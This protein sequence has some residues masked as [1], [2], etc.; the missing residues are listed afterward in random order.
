M[1]KIR[2]NHPDI[3]PS[4]PTFSR[5]VRAGNTL[6]IAGCTA[7]GTEAQGQPVMEQLR[8][9]L[10]RI[11]RIVAAEGGSPSD[12]VKITTFV[13]SIPQWR[14]DRERQEALFAEFFQGQYPA[15]TLVEITALAEDGLDVE[16]EAIVELG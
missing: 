10:D 15:N 7:R 13:T 2:K 5:S 16:I 1:E 12:I 11:V 9:T 4:G 8:V 3:A 14:A 6:Y